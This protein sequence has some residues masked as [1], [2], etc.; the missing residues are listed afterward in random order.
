MAK[1]ISKTYGEAIFELAVS[2]NK[3]DIFMEEIQMILQV[4][5]EN[6]QFAEI[7][8][9]PKIMKEEKLPEASI[10]I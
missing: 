8:N 7:M 10:S 2:E 6:P 5:D 3:T 1:L 9:H 4:L